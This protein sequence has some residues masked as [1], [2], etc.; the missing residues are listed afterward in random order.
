VKQLFEIRDG[1]QCRVRNTCLCFHPLQPKILCI[2]DTPED[3]LRAV[4]GVEGADEEPLKKRMFFVHVDEPVI[5][6]EA[7]ATHEA[8]L[9]A[10]VSQGKR[11]RLELQGDKERVYGAADALLTP[12]STGSASLGATG[13]DTSTEDSPSIEAGVEQQRLQAL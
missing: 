6:P 13:S 7:V 4:D 5:A 10:I 12:T 11:R 9:D 3:W 1:G 2:N 8:D